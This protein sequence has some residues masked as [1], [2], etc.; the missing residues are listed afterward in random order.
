M[1]WR[2][3]TKAAKG[4][5]LPK[6]GGVAHHTSLRRD[7]IGT[8]LGVRIAFPLHSQLPPLYK[9]SGLSAFKFIKRRRWCVPWSTG[10]GLLTTLEMGGL[11]GRGPTKEAR[12]V[13]LPM[14][15]LQR[16]WGRACCQ[17]WTP[18]SDR[19]DPLK[20]TRGWV[21]SSKSHGRC[22][23]DQ[24]SPTLGLHPPEGGPANISHSFTPNSVVHNP[25]IY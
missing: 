13:L 6:K 11:A 18:L 14:G 24:H 25:L 10:M 22:Q 20:V 1:P 5:S 8:T 4:E 2:T 9:F 17:H 23:S 16:R 21:N 15:I 3:T 12:V 7:A 19:C